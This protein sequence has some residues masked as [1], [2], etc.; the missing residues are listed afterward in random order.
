MKKKSPNRL[1]PAAP[2]RQ[3]ITVGIIE[4]LMK[5]PSSGDARAFTRLSSIEEAGR[6][7]IVFA[8]DRKALDAALASD[9]GL[10]LAPY[11]LGAQ[12]DSRVLTLKNPKYVFAQCAKYFEGFEKTFVHPAAIIDPAA[13]IGHGTSVGAGSVIEAGAHVG[14][15]CKIG[16]NVT[17]HGSAVVGDYVLVQSGAVLGSLGFG[18]VRGENGKY[19]RFPQQGTLVIE[20]E[21]EIGANTTIDRGALG[22]TRIGSGTKIDNMVHIGHNCRIGKNVIMA[23]Q[24]GISGS[25]T[26]EDGAI[27][28][29]QVGLG[30]R[31]HIG[32]GVVLGGQGGVFPGKEVNGPGQVFAGTPAEPLAN[33]LKTLAR[34]RRLK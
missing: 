26:I 7:S 30:D 11:E 18:Y 32:P 16:N 29:G 27:F 28:A 4:E 8:Q 1:E 19:L 25:C 33:Y 6:D 24:V 15:Y 21:V 5:M 2:E 14:E 9:A 31:V 34:I 10:I 17:I 22:E 13:H 23:A 3:P 20:D 12:E